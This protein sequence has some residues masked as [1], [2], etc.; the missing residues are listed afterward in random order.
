MIGKN[1]N[2]SPAA[3]PKVDAVTKMYNVELMSTPCLAHAL[4][5]FLLSQTQLN[6]IRIKTIALKSKNRVGTRNK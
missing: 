4:K 3:L 5:P 1:I 6:D 2:C